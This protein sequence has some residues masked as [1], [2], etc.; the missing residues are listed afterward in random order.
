MPEIRMPAVAGKFYPA[1][2]DQLNKQIS[3][4]IGDE[5]VAKIDAL[6]C[7]LPHAGYTYSGNVAVKTASRINFR[8]KIILLGP[9]HTGE[10]VPFSIMTKGLWQT[11]LGG[12]KIDSSLAG[13]LLKSSKYLEEDNLAH[14]Y[15]HSLEVE[16]PIVQFFKPDFEIVPIVLASD[17]ISSLKALGKEIAGVVRG[18][19]KKDSIMI[20]ASSDMTHY[21]TQSSAESKDK[22]AIQAVLD[23]DEDKLMERV[24]RL[25]ISMCG[26]APVVVM[27]S[28]S[29]L[30]GAKSAQL[31]KYQTSGDVTGDKSA[32]VGYAGI[33][34][35]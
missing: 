28:A 34:I 22:Q 26:F 1:K 32:V 20:L 18:S 9:N 31:V 6:A 21:E 19:E 13:D 8:D 30:L 27:L 5:K 7:M 23:L 16:L 15:E 35:Q 2:A 4:F 14:L 10:G 24:R 29:K 33:I 25:D 12:I 3:S 11:P 17:D